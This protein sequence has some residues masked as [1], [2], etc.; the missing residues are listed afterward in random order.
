MQDLNEARLA[1]ISV[2][3]ESSSSGYI[4]RTALMKYMYFLQTLRS[5]PLGY[6]FTLYSYGPFDSEVLA[7]LGSAEAL[8]AVESQA[9]LYRGG[10]GYRIKPAANSNWLESRNSSFLRKYKFDIQWVVNEFGSFTSS[11]LELVSTIIYAD[12]EAE[13]WKE[14]IS[15]RDLAER[16]HEVK[17]HFSDAQILSFA[18]QLADRRLLKAAR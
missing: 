4:G 5:V 10:Y 1:L 9:V 8:S 15:L 17:P 13:R 14:R 11:E 2:F 6:R 3:A 7:D 12:R 16:V 18:S